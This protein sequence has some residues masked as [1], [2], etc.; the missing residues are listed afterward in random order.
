[1]S[2]STRQIPKIAFCFPTSITRPQSGVGFQAVN[3]KSK[4]VGRTEQVLV[5][6]AGSTTT[7]RSVKTKAHDRYILIESS[8]MMAV[9]VKTAGEDIPDVGSGIE[10]LSWWR[11]A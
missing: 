2:I 9:V 1:M 7:T 3:G 10:M 4:V 11:R 6:T 5:L 8:G